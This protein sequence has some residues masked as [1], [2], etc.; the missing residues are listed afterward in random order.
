MFSFDKIEKIIGYKFQNRK[1]LNTAFVHS[2]YAN[3]HKVECN[4]RL[5]YLGDAVLEFIITDKLYSL[6]NLGEGQLT[7]Y[8]ASLVNEDTLS[9]IVSELNLDSFLLKGKGEKKNGIDSKAIKC[10]L[11][12]AIVGAIYLDSGIE[13]AKQFVLNVMDSFLLYK[14]LKN[15]K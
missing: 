7:K 4:E 12:E 11:F 13:F 6:F 15:A 5:E 8:R 14:T 2:S 1:L 3:E 9:F 10:D